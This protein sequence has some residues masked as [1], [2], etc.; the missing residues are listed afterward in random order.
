MTTERQTAHHTFAENLFRLPKELRDLVYADVFSDLAPVPLED[1]EI[2]SAGQALLALGGHPLDPGFEEEVL[3]SYHTYSTFSVRF[4]DHKDYA[5]LIKRGTDNTCPCT[6]RWLPEP[7][8]YQ[9]VRNLIIHAQEAGIDPGRSHFS[10]LEDLECM[11]SNNHFRLVWEQLL[12][13]PRLEQLTIRLQKQN[14]D[15]FSWASFTP[16]LSLLRERSPKLRV[17]L[18]ISFDDLLECS[19]SDP[20]WENNTEPG[21]V[22]EQPYDPMGFAN[23]TELIEEPTKED[24]KHV[25]EYF[26]K[27]VKTTGQDILRGLLDETASQR[28]ALALHYVVKEPALLRVRIKEHYEVYKRMRSQEGERAPQVS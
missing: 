23:I 10:S 27:E 8:H 22:V 28:R 2:S 16:I 6:V 24:I 14:N 19:W 21:N 9:Y 1:A 5:C 25:E 18:S 26:P 17:S 3:E 11:H 12:T 20:I 13:L 7:Q 4:P 15:V